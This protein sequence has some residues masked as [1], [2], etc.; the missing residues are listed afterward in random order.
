MECCSVVRSVIKTGKEETQHSTISSHQQI[1]Y[2][3]HYYCSIVV[4]SVMVVVYSTKYGTVYHILL[5]INIGYT[6][7]WRI[8]CTAQHGILVLRQRVREYKRESML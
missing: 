6:L 2:Y 8:D 1:C 3:C 5:P 4:G 7:M